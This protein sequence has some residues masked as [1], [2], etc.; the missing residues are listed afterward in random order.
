MSELSGI[1]QGKTYKINGVDIKLISLHLDEATSKLLEGAEGSSISEQIKAVQILVK[2]MLKES[3]PGATEKEL[4]DCMRLGTFMPLMDAF[5][6]VNGL[7]D[8]MG[9]DADK[10]KNA[11]KQREQARKP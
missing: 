6:D 7:K 9:T 2:R 3:I 10:I 8:K 4:K 5:Y 1:S 11:I